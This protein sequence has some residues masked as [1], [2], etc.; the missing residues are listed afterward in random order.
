MEFYHNFPSVTFAVLTADHFVGRNE[1]QMST[2]VKNSIPYSQFLRLRPLCSEES[3]F[4][5]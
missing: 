5:P 4:F 2:H 3:D 1:Q